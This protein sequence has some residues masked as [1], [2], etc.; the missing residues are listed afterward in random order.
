M[1]GGNAFSMNRD[2]ED[3]RHVC[4][5]M[6][7]GSRERMRFVLTKLGGLMSAPDT[8]SLISGVPRASVRSR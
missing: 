7:A 4:V 6:M 8:A 2:G 5:S 3:R 1:A